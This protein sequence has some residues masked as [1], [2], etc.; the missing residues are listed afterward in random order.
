MLIQDPRISCQEY[1]ERQPQKTLAYAKALKYWAKKANQPKADELH[2]LARCLHELRWTMRPFTTFTDGAVFKGT[3][4][5]QGTL[6]EGATKPGTMETTQT[7]VP[8]RRP[9][10]SPEK[11]TIPS[12]EEPDIPA[13]AS[14]E[15]ATVPTRELAVPPTPPE[16]D[17]KV[18][19]LESPAHELPQLDR[20]TPILPGNPSGA[21]PLK[22]G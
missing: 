19:E 17:K 4:P 7:A 6:Q 16:A 18:E 13:T 3:T 9:A 12:A 8:E 14:R 15:P 20:N 10:T 1:R 11:P 2:L 21:S 22:F 5:K